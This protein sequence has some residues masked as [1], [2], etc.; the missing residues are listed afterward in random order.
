M[1]L[2]APVDLDD[3]VLD[4]VRRLRALGGHDIPAQVEAAR[5]DGSAR[6]LA[7]LIRNLADNAFEHATASVAFE[8]NT[9]DGMAELVVTDDGPGIPAGQRETI[10]ERFARL[11]SSRP[12]NETHGGF[13]LGLAIARQIALSHRGTLTTHERTDGSTGAQFLL[14]LPLSDN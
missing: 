4:E 5:V 3:L 10:F 8:L 12:R 1:T 11:E 14:R 6:D 9:V 13:G 2:P 7:R